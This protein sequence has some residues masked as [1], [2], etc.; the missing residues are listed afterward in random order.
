MQLLDNESVSQPFNQTATQ[1][2]SQC[3]EKCTTTR[4]VSLC[5]RQP[6]NQQVNQSSRQL[7]SRSVSAERDTRSVRHGRGKKWL[8]LCDVRLRCYRAPL[9]QQTQRK[10]KH[11]IC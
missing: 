1:P 4:A 6:G 10:L 9:G 3:V 2:A 11:Y 8:P 7:A 5:S